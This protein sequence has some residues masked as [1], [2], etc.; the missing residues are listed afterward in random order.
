MSC[1]GCV[2]TVE[3]ALKAVPGVAEASVNFAEHTAMVTGAMEASILV[4]AVKSAGYEAAELTGDEDI[5]EKESIEL[6]HYR[7]L[8]K[9]SAVAGVIG[10]P[11]LVSGALGFMPGL[12]SINEQIFW[13][14]VGLAS[15]F[16]LVYSGGHFYSGAWKAF[17]AHNAN[18]DTLIAL[19]TGT[20]WVY[21]MVL[22]IAPEIVPVSVRHVYFE[23]A[24]II[25]ALI[26]FGSALE[27][28]ARGKTSEAIK[29][30]IGL[31]PK[32]A[33]IIRNGE[34]MDIPIADIGLDE[35][36]RVRPGEKVPL[37]GL[38]IEGHS[39]VDESMLT[40]EPIPVEKNVGDSA[41]GGTLNKSGTFLLQAK[42]IGKDTALARIIEMVRQ[43]QGSKPAIGLRVAGH[44]DGIDHRLP[45]CAWV[46]YAHLYYGR[47]GQGGR[48]WRVNT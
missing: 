36:I 10:L 18:M 21:S 1:A 5:A 12:D 39:S 41:V 8:L 26:N 28:R 15:L 40:G 30:L 7:S 27:M 46:G 3:D 24:A 22:S 34:E 13:V 25:I 43:A 11:L 31:Q 38:I 16:V 9:K 37:D 4:E 33:R 19:G 23:A 32:T 45:L 20:A 48:V 47:S 35:T 6:A 44:H 42:L 17:R 2:T 29:R 14:I